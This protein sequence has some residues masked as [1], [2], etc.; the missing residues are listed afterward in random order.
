MSL[1]WLIA[2]FIMNM[3]FLLIENE[4][5]KR[6]DTWGINL[7]PDKTDENF[8]EYDSMINLKPAHGNRTCN[9]ESEEIQKKIKEIVSC[10]VK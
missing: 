8:V 9:V 5:S 7:Y 6:E 10:I 2:N 4:N 1:W 3:E